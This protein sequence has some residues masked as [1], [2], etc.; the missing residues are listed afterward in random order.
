VNGVEN[1]VKKSGLPIEIMGL[2]MGRPI[3]AAK[4]KKNSKNEDCGGRGGIRSSGGIS[5]N[6]IIISDVFLIYI[7]I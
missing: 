6:T 2:L 4:K 7:T 1:G 5:E 3:I